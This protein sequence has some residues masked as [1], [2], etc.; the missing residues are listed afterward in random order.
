MR[1][2]YVV[3]SP[4]DTPVPPNGSSDQRGSSGSSGSYTP[5]T[6]ASTGAPKVALVSC[7]R[8]PGCSARAPAAVRLTTTSTGPVESA[9]RAQVPFVRWACSRRSST[10]QNTV[11]PSGPSALDGRRY[12]RDCAAVADVVG[13]APSSRAAAVRTAWS[14]VRPPGPASAPETWMPARAGSPVSSRVRPWSATERPKPSSAVIPTTDSSTVT[15]AAA[16]STGW[17]RARRSTS[18]V[19]VRAGRAVRSMVRASP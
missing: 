10:A 16:T 4:S 19:G 1:G 5:R 14:C 15:K 13:T 9:G 7:S 8:D 17:A 2:P 11:S 12:G 18:P 3:Y 6:T